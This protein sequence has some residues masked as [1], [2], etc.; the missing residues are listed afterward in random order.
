MHII[1]KFCHKCEQLKTMECFHKDKSHRDNLRSTC[2]EC[3]NHKRREF[4]KNNRCSVILS[5]IKDRCN[6]PNHIGYKW[7]GGRGIKCLITEEELKFLWFRDKAFEMK[8]PSIDRINNKGNYE[9]NNCQFLELSKN[10]IKANQQKNHKQ[11]YQYDKKGNFIKAWK[12]CSEISKYF[13]FRKDSIRKV[14][15]NYRK[16]SYGYIWS[17]IRREPL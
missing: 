13:G 1:S 12:S 4:K 11:I 9:L 17:Y 16:S 2:K 8:K 14:C 10:S 6:N 5:N 15:Y 7:Y 3:T